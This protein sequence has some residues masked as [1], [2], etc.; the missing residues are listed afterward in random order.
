MRAWT[1]GS[2]VSLDG[3]VCI[4]AHDRPVLDGCCAIPRG[5]CLRALACA[6]C[7]AP[8][9]RFCQAGPGGTFTLKLTPLKLRG[10]TVALIHHRGG[11]GICTLACW[12]RKC[13]R[14][15]SSA[16]E[17]QRRPPQRWASQNQRRHSGCT[18]AVK[19]HSPWMAPP[20]PPPT[21]MK[22]SAVVRINV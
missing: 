15:T 16:Q 21:R 3:S 10:R 11:I 8:A 20:Y 12:F 2:G 6:R 1:H 14:A 19:R 17:L 22:V 18:A 5:R 4:A 7:R 9:P 13:H